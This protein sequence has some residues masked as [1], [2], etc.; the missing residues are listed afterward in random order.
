MAIPLPESELQ[1]VASQALIKPVLSDSRAAESRAISV[2]ASPA[3]DQGVRLPSAVGALWLPIE[4][5][6][7]PA[8]RLVVLIPDMDVAESELAARIWA[9]ASPRELEVLYLGTLHEQREEFRARR[10]LATLAA[11]TRDDTVRVEIRLVQDSAWLQAVQAVWRS[12]DLIICHAE[13]TTAVGGLQRVPLSQALMEELNTPVCIL[14][15]YYPE[16][17]REHPKWL[18]EL[19]AWLPPLVLV[20]IFFMFQVRITQDAT[21]WAQTVLLCL[22]VLLEFGLIA[23][24]EHFLDRL[25]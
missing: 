16:L 20:V 7:P 13:Q 5:S 24:W 14:S 18:A 25:N 12:G 11:I 2:S 23:I 4:V 9:L 3:T 1:P 17:P 8:Q 19:L 15:G 6:I 10:R 22:S 21:G